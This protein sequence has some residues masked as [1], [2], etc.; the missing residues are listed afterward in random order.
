MSAKRDRAEERPPAPWGKFPLAELT[1]LA[2]IIL[3]IVG[4][5]GGSPTALGLGIALGAL[6]GLEVSIRE[7]FAGFRSHTTVLAAAPAVLTMAILFFT[8]APRVA[9][10]G[11]G[12]VVFL[13]AFYVLREVFKRRSGG[14]GFR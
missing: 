2:G 7:H 5:I 10:L 4:F 3:L 14:F 13:G 8:N 1:I 6:G 9:M 11:A 12:V